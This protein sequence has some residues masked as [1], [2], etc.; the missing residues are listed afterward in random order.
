MKKSMSALEM[1]LPSES[2]EWVLCLYVNNMVLQIKTPYMSK[3]KREVDLV[4]I[5]IRMPIVSP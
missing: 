5:V 4:I 3:K 2:T 1:I